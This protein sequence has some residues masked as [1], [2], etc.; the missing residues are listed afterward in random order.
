MA[1]GWWTEYLVLQMRRKKSGICTL[2]I[3]RQRIKAVL[4]KFCRNPIA[5]LDISHSKHH[6]SIADSSSPGYTTHHSHTEDKR[7]GVCVG[8]GG[9]G[10]DFCLNRDWNHQPLH[11]VPNSLTTSVPCR[12]F[13]WQFVMSQSAS[14]AE[15]YNSCDRQVYPTVHDRFL[16]VNCR[17]LRSWCMS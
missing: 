10:R 17:S 5:T 16:L 8:G 7:G 3:P 6:D 1:W 12:L 9:G 14:L 15:T 4:A 2:K 13:E 11:A